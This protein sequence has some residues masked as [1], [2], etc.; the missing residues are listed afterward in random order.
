MKFGDTVRSTL[1]GN[2]FNDLITFREHL[3]GTLEGDTW[4]LW[5]LKKESWGNHLRG[6]LKG[7][8][9]ESCQAI[10]EKICIKQFELTIYSVKG[11]KCL[12]WV[13]TWFV[14][15][16][17]ALSLNDVAALL[18]SSGSR[19]WAQ[20]RI[21]VKPLPPTRINVMEAISDA[22]GGRIRV[23]NSLGIAFSSPWQL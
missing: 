5:T 8:I 7:A 20:Y 1:E 3:R 17:W 15:L 19:L 16:F 21:S 13:L 6:T 22:D 10:E 11:D 2:T 23:R 18:K 14:S 4:I 9:T 12:N